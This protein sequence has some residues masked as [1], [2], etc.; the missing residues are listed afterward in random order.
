[1]ANIYFTQN[2]VPSSAPKDLVDNASNFDDLLLG[3]EPSYPDRLG[4]R[5]ESWAGLTNMVRDAIAQIGYVYTNPSVYQA[6][7]VISLPN[8]IFNKDGEWYKPK[9]GVSLPY[10]TTGV[11][12]SESAN[13]LSIGDAALRSDLA[14]P[15]QGIALVAGG[16]RST[17][18]LASLRLLTA[19]AGAT[20]FV[21][22]HSSG[23]YGGGVYRQVPGD[24][25][26]ADDGG[27]R[28]TSTDGTRWR[29][30]VAAGIEPEVYGAIH[31][32]ATSDTQAI[33]AA[34][35]YAFTSRWPVVFGG[36]T[37]ALGV[38]AIPAATYCLLSKGV[39]LKGAGAL[40]TIFVP[41]AGLSNTID[42]FQIQP[43]SG[44][45]LDWMEIR[46]FIVYPG[47]GGSP[48]GKRV[49]VVYE[50]VASNASSVIFDGVYCAPG[51]DYSLDWTAIS[52]TNP[53]G[54]PANSVFTRNH[55]WEGVRMVNS[56]DSISFRNNVF[57]SAATSGR[58][59]LQ[60]EGVSAAGGQPAQFS[61]EY[62]NFDCDGGAVWLKNGLS[63]KIRY[64]NIEQ[65]HGSGSSSSAVVDIDGNANQL[66]WCEVSGNNFGIFGTANVGQAIRVN[67]AIQTKVRDNRMLCAGPGFASRA[68]L[69]TANAID[70]EVSGNEIDSG[71]GSTI[72]D[73][74][75]G[76]RGVGKLLTPLNSFGNK[77]SGY[78]PL[79][80][81]KGINGELSIGGALTCPAS[82]SGQL[83]ASLPVGMRPSYA[84]SV[85]GAC[86]AGGSYAPC[87]IDIAT[88]GDIVFYASVAS[89]SEFKFNVTVGGLGFVLGSL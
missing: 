70:T 89:P 81:V 87:V 61:A 43:T 63:A 1:M 57:R 69:L 65:T 24:V 33:Q 73:S 54:G 21:L 4:F 36:Y 71:F 77:G 31:D 28:I 51:N 3:S 26:T 9:A 67:N 72:L 19:A 2:P 15:A 80:V 40:K 49:F 42:Y 37:Y 68:I 50:G 34:M 16:F 14:N 23:K 20:V 13:F 58:V 79:W 12:A 39:S 88:N 85:S 75:V 32:G 17:P 60:V 22:A 74:G 76:T 8:Q 41:V 10:T 59:G 27:Y 82:P 11:W 38:S 46:D 48:L 83:V 86:I 78:Q 64:N 18:D 62:N 25:T 45:V 29:R 66:G 53:Q 84:Q 47:A 7:I 35:D 5:R 44:A 52:G 56:G 55:F 6:G 30:D